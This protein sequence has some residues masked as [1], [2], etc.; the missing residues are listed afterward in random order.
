MPEPDRPQ[1]DHAAGATASAM[2]SLVGT[3]ELEAGPGRGTAWVPAR[4]HHTFLQDTTDYYG[5]PERRWNAKA[6]AA[7]PTGLATVLTG[8]L[9][10]SMPLLL[11]GGAIAFTLGLIG[12]RQCR[13]RGNRGKG[14]ALAGMILGAFAL[15][16]GLMVLILAG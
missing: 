2:P 10:H 4:P 6:I 7:G 16:F 3:R 12:S 11:I 9:A 14:F 8:L 15:F 5:E 1:Q 13:D